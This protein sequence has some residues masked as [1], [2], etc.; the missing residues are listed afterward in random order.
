MDYPISLWKTIKEVLLA[1]LPI[2]FEIHLEIV[3]YFRITLSWL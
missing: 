1:N 3:E 2:C